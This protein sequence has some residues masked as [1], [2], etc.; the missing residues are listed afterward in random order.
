MQK[1]NNKTKYVAISR[2]KCYNASINVF[3]HTKRT[4][5]KLI[6]T[7]SL[8]LTFTSCST[9]PLK[10]SQEG[11]ECSWSK[12]FTPCEPNVK[13]IFS[14]C[15]EG[16]R[17]LADGITGVGFHCVPNTMHSTSIRTINN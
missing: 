13:P 3:S 11:P 7:L 10:A 17:D 12:P 15:P 5:M 6:T 9:I 4:D 14:V 2:S 16:Y 8:L 1:P